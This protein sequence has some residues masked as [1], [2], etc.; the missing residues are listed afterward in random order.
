MA[1]IGKVHINQ[2]TQTSYGKIKITNSIGLSIVDP[3]QAVKVNVALNDL[4]DV[5]TANVGD[6]YTLIYNTNTNSYSMKPFDI[7]NLGIENIEGGTF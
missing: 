3:E 6:G 5:N 7:T 2:P 4:T 1:N